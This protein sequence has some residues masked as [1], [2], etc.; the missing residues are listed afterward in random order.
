M[1][2]RFRNYTQKAGITDDYYKVRAFL[3]K[4]GYSEFVYARWDWMATHSYLDKSAV[5]KIGIWEDNGILV[6]I[7]T[8]DTT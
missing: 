8:F 4:L 1:T 5:G 3:V 7:A 2:V 6:G